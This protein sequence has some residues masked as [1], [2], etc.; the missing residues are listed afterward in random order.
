MRIKIVLATGLSLT[1]I[2]VFIALLH[3]PST[4]ALTNG[5]QPSTLLVAATGDAGACQRGETLPARTSA[6]RLQIEATTGPRVSVEVLQDGRIVTQGTKGT[7]WYGSTVTIPVRSFD[8]TLTHTTVCLQLSA[9]SG[10]VA[11]YGATTKRT[12]AA[13]ANGRPL[14]G[15]LR[16]AY[17]RSAHQSWWSLAGSVIQHMG[18]GRPASGTWIVLPI[19]ALAAAAI[20]VGSWIL[21]RELQ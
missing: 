6:I 15:R 13:T 16:I 9:L 5:V 10:E 8:R 1:A 18:L 3:S 17:L 21:T 19:A 4:V 7:A 12:I 2:A 11:L 14:P 20:A